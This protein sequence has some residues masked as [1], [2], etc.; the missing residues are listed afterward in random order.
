MSTR[1]IFSFINVLGIALLLYSGYSSN[2]TASKVTV[3]LAFPFMLID[4]VYALVDTIASPLESMF[5][6]TILIVV[7]LLCSAL[8]LLGFFLAMNGEFDDDDE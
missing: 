5:W 8:F 7:C 1:S 2:R 4:S 6:Q 3:R